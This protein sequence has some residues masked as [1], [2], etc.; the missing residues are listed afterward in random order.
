MRFA[1][2]VATAKMNN[3]C[4]KALCIRDWRILLVLAGVMAFAPLSRGDNP[5]TA[6][7]DQTVFKPVPDSEREPLP[8]DAKISGEAQPPESAMA[9]W[10]RSPATKFWEGL[11]LG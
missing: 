2:P 9:W 3:H 1:H 7:S 6:A 5:G 10:Y 4:Q 8:F 11:P